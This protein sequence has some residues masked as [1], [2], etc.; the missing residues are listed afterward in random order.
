[1]FFIFMGFIGVLVFTVKCVKLKMFFISMYSMSDCEDSAQS[2]VGSFNDSCCCTCFLL[3]SRSVGDSHNSVSKSGAVGQS[4]FVGWYLWQTGDMI[5]GG[6]PD[7]NNIRVIITVWFLKKQTKEKLISWK[8]L[9]L[10]SNIITGENMR[11]LTWGFLKF[12][13]LWPP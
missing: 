10:F 6:F 4:L 13:S 2:G 5:H 12:K 7:A 9:S 1:M 11:G 3:H 8:L